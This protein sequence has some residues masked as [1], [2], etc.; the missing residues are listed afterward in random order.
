MPAGPVQPLE[1]PL[2]AQSPRKPP[3]SLDAYEN[4]MKFLDR[5]PRPA[6]YRASRHGNCSSTLVVDALGRV[7]S[8]HGCE[9]HSS[10]AESEGRLTPAERAKFAK[11]IAEWMREPPQ[12]KQ[13]EQCS[14]SITWIGPNGATRQADACSPTSAA[15]TEALDLEED[16]RTTADSEGAATFHP[17][18][19]PQ[20]DD[21]RA[22]RPWTP[23]HDW[24]V[25]AAEHYGVRQ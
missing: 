6:L 3:L 9:G 10:G 7:W 5:L 16:F 2:A 1:A 22:D 4:A 18:W 14:S 11:A 20:A 19:Y 12:R 17:M 15:L 25:E 13:P 23:A 8:E 21:L 24:I